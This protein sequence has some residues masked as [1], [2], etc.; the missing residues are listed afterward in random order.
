MSRNQGHT[1]NEYA[2]LLALLALLGLGSLSLLGK[3]ISNLFASVTQPTGARSLQNYMNSMLSPTA[4]ATV[5]L[6][7]NGSQNGSPNGLMPDS[8]PISALGGSNL[9]KA[10]SP[11]SVNVS[12]VDG[13]NHTVLGNL[14]LAQRLDQLA[15]QASDPDTQG[16]FA[17]LAKMA[18]YMGANEGQIDN[19]DT[20]AKAGSYTNGDALNDLIDLSASFNKLLINPPDNVSSADLAKVTPIANQV[21]TISDKYLENLHSVMDG[22][23]SG[24]TYIN[25]NLGSTSAGLSPNGPPISAGDSAVP[26][27]TFGT[28]LKNTTYEALVP[29]DQ[30]KAQVDG[31][32]NANPITQDNAPVLTTFHNAKTTDE[33]DWGHH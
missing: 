20:Y 9:L 13:N 31:T 32:L 21:S 19:F 6:T 3:S 15:Q 18:Y 22:N 5:M 24:K 16:Y 12:S 7:Q 2:L 10:V 1:I 30:L 29:Y 27:A 33:K 4:N 8:Q 11:V 14:R 25:F 17:Q 26:T 28:G 23:S